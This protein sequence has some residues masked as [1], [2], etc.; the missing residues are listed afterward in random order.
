[1]S[2]DPVDIRINKFIE[3]Q[4]NEKGSIVDQIQGFNQDFTQSDDE[5]EDEEDY[6]LDLSNFLILDD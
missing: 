2:K 1:M 4:V 5:L 6:T 3:N